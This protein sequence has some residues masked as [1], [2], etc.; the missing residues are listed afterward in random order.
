MFRSNESLK[1]SVDHVTVEINNTLDN[2][3]TYLITLPKVRYRY[4]SGVYSFKIE[5]I[6]LLLESI[7]YGAPP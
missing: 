6:Y 2:L 5:I 3:H 7:L 4:Y 1:V